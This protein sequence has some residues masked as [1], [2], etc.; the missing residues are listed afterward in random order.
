MALLDTMVQV[1]VLLSNSV[2]GVL[3][4]TE[5]EIY[6]DGHSVKNGAYGM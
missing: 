2:V 4:F 3:E 5:G 1:R 6:I